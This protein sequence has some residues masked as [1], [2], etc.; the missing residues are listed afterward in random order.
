MNQMDGAFSICM[1]TFRS[2]W[3]IGMPIIR[4]DFPPPRPQVLSYVLELFPYL[5]SGGKGCVLPGGGLGIVQLVDPLREIPCNTSAQAL[6]SVF[7]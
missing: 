7:A 6:M 3:L 5:I 2:G 1:E 4:K